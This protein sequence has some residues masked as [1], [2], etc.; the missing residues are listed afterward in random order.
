V[1]VKMQFAVHKAS[2]TV[3]MVNFHEMAKIVILS[4][5]AEKSTI[6]VIM[7]HHVSICAKTDCFF[8]HNVAVLSNVLGFP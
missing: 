2:S 6:F 4:S 8:G 3:H 1:T 7:R 5:N